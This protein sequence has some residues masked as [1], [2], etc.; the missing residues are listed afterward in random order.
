MTS[1]S[2]FVLACDRLTSSRTAGHGWVRVV[3]H[4]ERHWAVGGR[5]TG[6]EKDDG[7][8]AKNLRTPRLKSGLGVKL[9]RREDAVDRGGCEKEEQFDELDTIGATLCTG[10]PEP[11]VRL[12]LP[13]PWLRLRLPEPWGPMK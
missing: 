1:L 12:R 11:W 13:E 3:D 10:P 5:G 6:P 9:G 4:D 8:E 2:K 7:S